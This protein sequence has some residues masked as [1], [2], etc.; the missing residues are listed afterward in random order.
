MGNPNVQNTGISF[1]KDLL[2]AWSETNRDSDIPRFQFA[3]Q[4][5]DDYAGGTSDRFLTDASTLTLQTVNLGYTLP[6]KLV[7]RL[8]ISKLRVYAAGENLCYW[9]RRKGFDPRGSFWGT[10]TT[11][12]YSPVR[13]ITGGFTVTF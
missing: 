4:P 11:T 3:V 8:G 12:T 2:N 7:K 5:V 6:D 10:T 13:M 1:H 9:S